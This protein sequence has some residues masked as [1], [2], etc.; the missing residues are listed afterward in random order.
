MPI[1]IRVPRLGWSME[2]G[3]FVGWLKRDGEAVKA[4]EPLFTL[5]GDK[6]T[7]DVEAI[8]SG[9]LCIPPEAPQPGSTVVVGALLGY[10]LRAGEKLPVNTPTLRAEPGTSAA[11]PTAVAA[12][13]ATPGSV[14]P[15][16]GAQNSRPAPV[17]QAGRVAIS[18]RALRLA[19]E[20][21]VDWKGL[22]GTGRSGRIR[23]SDVLAAAPGDPPRPASA[24]AEPSP[25]TAAAHPDRLHLPERVP[26]GTIVVTDW[27]FPDLAVEEAMLRPLG[28]NL[29]ARQCRTEDELIA[30]TADADVVITQFARLN[31]SVIAPMR[32]ARAIVRYGIGVDNIDLDAAQKCGLPV[33]N[34]PDYCIDE[35]ADQTL[36]FLLALT[37]GVVPHAEHVRAGRWGLA[38]P[39]TAMQALADLTVGVVGF[40]RIGREVVRRLEPFRCRVVVLDP[41]VPPEVIAQSGATPVGTL[42]ELLPACDVLTLHCP[43][44]ARTRRMLHAGTLA[45]L[46][47]GALLLNVARGDLIDTAALVGALQSGHVAAAALD[48]CDPEPIPADHPLL[49]LPNVIL[50]PHVA[51][52][53]PKAVR[54]LRETVATLAALALTDALPPN[55]VNGVKAVRKLDPLWR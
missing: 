47:H 24:R 38:V 33:C 21:G 37:R 42:E 20:L 40:G 6:A 26:P 11:P 14:P 41:A 25:S 44:T 46:K 16:V 31:A 13:G 52:V 34:V 22:R 9:V 51:S 15:S 55:V 29:V 54:T 50:A 48:V 27:T 30:L 43:S 32:R 53:S 10:L 45:Q 35:V 1:E 49:Q 39:M 2:E 5:E 12:R 7:Q 28:V 19:A 3:G 17:A 18:P 4:G 8:D 36:A 23:S